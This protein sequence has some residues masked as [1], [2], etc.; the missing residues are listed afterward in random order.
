MLSHPEI[1][2]WGSWRS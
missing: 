1:E 2:E